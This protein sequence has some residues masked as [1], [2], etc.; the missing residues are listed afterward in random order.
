LIHAA[1]GLLSE[2]LLVRLHG[3]AADYLAAD[4]EG[5]KAIVAACRREATV[6][7]LAERILGRTIYAQ[8]ASR[9]GPLRELLQNALDASPMGARI[10]VRSTPGIEGS[11]DRELT[12]ADAGRGMS[13]AEL[14]ED[15]LVPFRTRKDDDRDAIGEHGI[16]FLSAL[17]IAPAVDV[18]T[19]TATEA[20][21]LAIRP[22]GQRP[23][24]ADFT[25]TLSPLGAHSGARTGTT[26]RL[27]LG[28]PFDRAVL[29]AEAVAVVGLVDLGR[30]RI[31]VNGALINAPRARLR[32]A[33]RAPIGE[34][35]ELGEL[36]LL[37]GRG[38][39]LP[40]RFLL[41]QQGLCVCPR[42]DVFGGGGLGLHRD[43]ARALGAA[44]FALVAELPLS[45]PLNKGRSAVAA[46]AAGAV[47]R[48]VIAA[49]ERFVLEDALHNRELLRGVD[50][51]LG[52][53]LDR[54]VSAA[55]AGERP[56]PPPAR[57]AAADED[58]PT[59]RQRSPLSSS[60]AAPLD[61]PP[62]SDAPKTPTVAAPAEVVRFADALLDAPL[63]VTSTFEPGRGEARALRPLRAVLDAHRSGLLRAAGEPSVPGAIHLALGDPL[64]LALFRRLNMT[65]A[66]APPPERGRGAPVTLPRLGRDR[67]ASAPM[68][69]GMTALG[70]AM[71]ILER[72]DAAISAAADLVPSAISVHQDL[73]GPDE[74]AH[75]DGAGI[76][77]NVASPRIR[78]LLEAVLAGE[79]PVA[80]AA[81]VDLL[82]HE[83]AHVS[84]ASTIPPSTAEH[85]V[86]FYRRKDW[87]RRRLLEGLAGGAVID[88]SRW[89]TVARRSLGSVALPSPEALASAMTP[90]ELA[91]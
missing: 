32:R 51:R 85:G 80:F 76:S 40:P 61:P 14:L 62:A 75:T 89:I 60:L 3:R 11:G 43:L 84:L 4:D 33:A 23:P 59:L 52:S 88:P 27:A 7:D 81:L 44:G 54:L 17:E 28:E 21:H 24:Y 18:T 47:E 10:E 46:A 12:V 13:R 64:T 74:M 6:G 1:Q 22:V 72:I 65:R 86:S 69:P 90:G 91:A 57:D 39:G 35:G 30:A 25:W 20:S 56:T 8:S 31:F 70:A 63:F 41:T 73:Y 87:L 19:V 49:F 53:V 15:L 38:E 34:D 29:A 77:V 48:A 26:V 45:V 55:L 58:A 50:H 83:K 68:L 42:L 9:S 67:L 71:T 5:K 78:A 2:L 66:P 37:I 36:D 82:L 16:G 79:D